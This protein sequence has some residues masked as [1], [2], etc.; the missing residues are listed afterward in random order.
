MVDY[1]YQRYE[2][3]IGEIDM[4]EVRIT[5]VQDVDGRYV[6]VVGTGRN[7][8]SFKKATI[9]AYA[10]FNRNDAYG[11]PVLKTMT[12]TKNGKVITDRTK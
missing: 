6:D 10:D 2:P 12:I 1:I 8:R 9:A 3:L 11:S 4:I 7:Q 5:E